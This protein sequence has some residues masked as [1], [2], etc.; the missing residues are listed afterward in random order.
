MSG[1]SPHPPLSTLSGRAIFGVCAHGRLGEGLVCLAL[2]PSSYSVAESAPPDGSRPR[3]RAAQR[4]LLGP[5][6][7]GLLRWWSRPVDVDGAAPS[8]RVAYVRPWSRRGFPRGR[9][10]SR[11]APSRLGRTPCTRTDS[12]TAAP[13]SGCASMWRQ[14]SPWSRV[15]GTCPG[16]SRTF[17]LLGSGRSRCPPPETMVGGG[18]LSPEHVTRR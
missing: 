16:R 18:G 14:K 17:G 8:R 11:C 9:S 10:W 2:E 3:R 13:A 12:W 7:M 5:T 15:H 4:E 6:T 1:H